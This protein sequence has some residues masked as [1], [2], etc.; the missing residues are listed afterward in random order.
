MQL[1]TS[2]TN[3]V[4]MTAST[5]A[6]RALVWRDIGSADTPSHN[7]TANTTSALGTSAIAAG[8]CAVTTVASASVTTGDVVLWAFSSAPSS[9][10]NSLEIRPYVTSGNVNFQV[11]NATTGSITPAATSVNWKVTR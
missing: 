4:N 8:A 1:G 9:T 5:S 6:A 3:R 2:S 11:C 7:I 10:Y